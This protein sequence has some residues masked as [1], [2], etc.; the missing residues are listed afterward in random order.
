MWV[1]RRMGPHWTQWQ[2][3]TPIASGEA[4]IFAPRAWVHFNGMNGVIS[5]GGNVSSV[6]RVNVGDY[7]VNF[8]IGMPHTEYAL[9]AS[10]SNMVV[11]SL[12]PVS[13]SQVRMVAQTLVGTSADPSSVGL[14]AFA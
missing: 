12:W 14:A 13:T 7:I 1:R 4:P 5:C 2:S 10:A 3:T 6:T 9:T 8:G 11:I